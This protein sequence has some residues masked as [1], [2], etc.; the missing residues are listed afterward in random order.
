MQTATHR[1]VPL[2]YTPAV[3]RQCVSLV[4]RVI[5]LAV[6]LAGLAV[7]VTADIVVQFLII[8][9]GLI[10]AL[11][12]DALTATIDLGATPTW[13]DFVFALT[14]GTVAFTG[15]EAAS[16][17]AGEVSVGRRGLK[18][19]VSSAALVVLVSV[20]FW[21]WVLGPMGMLLAV[22]LT[23]SLKIALESDE[24]TRWLAVLMGGRPTRERTGR[25]GSRDVPMA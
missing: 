4:G 1:D 8:V 25:V 7:L 12:L 15:L 18:R 14:I 20:L 23:M 19:L 22:P 13:E 9:V 5:A 2:I 17:L 10:V 24:G 3:Q 11:D 21:G 6:S 16:G